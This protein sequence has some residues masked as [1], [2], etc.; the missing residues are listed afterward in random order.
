MFRSPIFNFLF[1][2]GFAVFFLGVL[3]LWDLTTQMSVRINGNSQLLE[4]LQVLQQEKQKLL[5]EYQRAS[6][7]NL[8][9]LALVIPVSPTSFDISTL[10]FF[11]ETI[12]RENGL[13][14]ESLEIDA[15]KEGKKG[16]TVPRQPRGPVAQP[17]YDV[18]ENPGAGSTKPLIQQEISVQGNVNLNEITVTIQALGTYDSLKAFLQA[19]EGSLRLIDVVSFT[20][21]K[22]GKEGGLSF[23]VVLKMYHQ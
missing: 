4:E 19:I 17:S 8:Q 14:I 22:Q 6:K 1:T 10:Y 3:P 5:K 13:R 9:R 15:L 7:E 20:L 12:G 21:S 23:L 2:L 11:F 16:G 18:I